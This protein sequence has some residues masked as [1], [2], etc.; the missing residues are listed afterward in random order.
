VTE[1]HILNIAF[2]AH[3]RLNWM[4]RE[5]WDEAMQENRRRVASGELDNSTAVIR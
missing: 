4:H 3:G 1:D 2:R 5:G